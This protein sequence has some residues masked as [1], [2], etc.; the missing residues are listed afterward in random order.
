MFFKNAAPLFGE[1][2]EILLSDVQELSFCLQKLYGVLCTAFLTP[3]LY[4]GQLHVWERPSTTL[5]RDIPYVLEDF[6]PEELIFLP[7][8]IPALL[9]NFLQQRIVLHGRFKKIFL[10]LLHGTPVRHGIELDATN[11][12]AYFLQMSAHVEK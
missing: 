2:D 1:L 5:S 12:R 6:P 4:F 10:K 7:A 3:G 11:E 8:A 9:Y